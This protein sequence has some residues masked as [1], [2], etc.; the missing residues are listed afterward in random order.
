MGNDE[1]LEEMPWVHLEDEI[2]QESYWAKLVWYSFNPSWDA[3]V[4]KIKK[5]YWEIINILNDVSYWLEWL[6][7]E[8]MVEKATLEAI[9]AQM[10]AVKVVTF[11]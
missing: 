7:T 9:T 10:W 1:N 11:K 4:Q 2:F 3:R 8:S 5:L 6:P